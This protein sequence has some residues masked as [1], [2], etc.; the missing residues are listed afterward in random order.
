[1][2]E[3]SDK[4]WEIYGKRDPYYGVISDEKF[5]SENIGEGEKDEADDSEESEEDEDAYTELDKKA[6][7]AQQAGREALAQADLAETRGAEAKR[8]QDQVA[9]LKKSEQQLSATL[10][11]AEKAE[12]CGIVMMALNASGA[13]WA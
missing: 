5:R 8:L 12:G 13:R 9:S 10:A 11:K 1:M 6:K 2:H 7:E 4:E 3:D